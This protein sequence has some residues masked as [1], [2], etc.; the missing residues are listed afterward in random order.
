[1][2]AKEECIG[3]LIEQYPV[4]SREQ[5]EKLVYLIFDNNFKVYLPNHFGRL[6]NGA[7]FGYPFIWLL[8]E[9]Q[10]GGIKYLYQNGIWQIHW[11]ISGRYEGYIGRGCNRTFRCGKLTTL[12]FLVRGLYKKPLVE[13]RSPLFNQSSLHLLPCSCLH[14]RIPPERYIYPSFKQGKRSLSTFLE[15]KLKMRSLPILF[16]PKNKQFNQDKDIVVV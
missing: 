1:M 16:K 11:D 3:F 2:Q 10:V 13:R 8:N 9:L 4:I 7:T 14:W 12:K 15:E 5:S 6:Y